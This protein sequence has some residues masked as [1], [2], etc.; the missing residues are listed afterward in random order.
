MLLARRTGI[1]TTAWQPTA[2]LPIANIYWRVTATSPSGLDGYPAEA[3]PLEILAAPLDATPP[4]ASIAFLGP[5][6]SVNDGLVVGPGFSI[7]VTLDDAEGSV[8]SWFPLIDGREA[9]RADLAGPWETGEHTVQIVAIDAV[10]NR[11]ESVDVAADV[12]VEI[13]KAAI[14]LP[15]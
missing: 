3:A 2:E 13:D 5:Q 15:D 7:E 8:E 10:G 6:A 9:T 11:G 1:T 4:V 14:G 12:A